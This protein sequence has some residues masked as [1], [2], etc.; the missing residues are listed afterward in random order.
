MKTI[1]DQ[2]LSEFFFH[3]ISYLYNDAEDC[4]ELNIFLVESEFADNAPPKR[5]AKVSFIDPIIWQQMEELHS[6]FDEYEIRDD[7]GVIQVIERSRY[8]D[9]VN[10]T[11]PWHEEIRGRAI[12]VRVWSHDI[13]SEVIVNNLPT[14]SWFYL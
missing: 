10:N 3:D 11:Y 5:L 6:S 9:F 1:L 7:G 4:N 14:V 13:V 12:H 2:S 8:F